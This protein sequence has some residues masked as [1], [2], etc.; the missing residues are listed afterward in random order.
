MRLFDQTNRTTS[1]RWSSAL[2]HDFIIPSGGC[3]FSTACCRLRWHVSLCAHVGLSG[4]IHLYRNVSLN[5]HSSLNRYISL[6]EHIALSGYCGRG[7]NDLII[8]IATNGE[9]LIHVYYS[10]NL[11]VFSSRIECL[12]FPHAWMINWKE[13]AMVLALW[14]HE[15]NPSDM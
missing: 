10:N 9:K 2:G 6:N 11:G 8:I 15:Q 7:P 3:I 5:W 4:H 12:N 14:Y 13:A 1:S